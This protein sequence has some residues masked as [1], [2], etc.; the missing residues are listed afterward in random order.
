MN[1]NN[2]NTQPL[3]AGRKASLAPW[4]FWGEI[5]RGGTA[6]GSTP[7]H[8][9][10]PDPDAVGESLFVQ[11]VDWTNRAVASADDL[12]AEVADDEAAAEIVNDMGDGGDNNEEEGEE[13]E[14]NNIIINNNNI[15]NTNALQQPVA[16]PHVTA[17]NHFCNNQVLDHIGEKGHDMTIRFDVIEVIVSQWFCVSPPTEI[18]EEIMEIVM[19]KAMESMN[20]TTS[21]RLGLAVILL[22]TPTTCV[23]LGMIVINIM[24]WSTRCW[25]ST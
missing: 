24:T 8:V 4:A 5:A 25:Q 14:A 10:D 2:N 13:E 16:S 7:S 1:N 23:G 3:P 15:I 22:K 18:K 12:K 20:T 19:K 21:S 9:T 17:D 11:I 6:F